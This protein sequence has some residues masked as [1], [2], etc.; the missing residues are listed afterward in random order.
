MSWH[1][2]SGIKIAFHHTRGNESWKADTWQDRCWCRI[3]GDLLSCLWVDSGWDWISTLNYVIPPGAPCGIRF[4]YYIPV[5][6]SRISW[7]HLWS[8]WAKYWYLYILKHSTCGS[9]RDSIWWCVQHITDSPLRHLQCWFTGSTSAWT[10]SNGYRLSPPSHIRRKADLSKHDP[11]LFNTGFATFSLYPWLAQL[12]L[13][14]IFYLF[15][16]ST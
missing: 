4:Y 15:F 13:F 14:F 1:V 7:H 5:Y 8:L 16:G 11:V 9:K 10:N 3:R 6:S 12:I 2:P